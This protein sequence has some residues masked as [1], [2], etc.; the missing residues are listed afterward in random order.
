MCGLWCGF[1][2]L[3]ALLLWLDLGVLN[4]KAHVIRTREALRWT[5]FWVSVSLAFSVFV[6][7]LYQRNWFG[8]GLGPG[9]PGSGFR[10][11]QQYVTGYVVEASLSLDNVFVIALI[12]QYFRVPGEYQHRTLF[13]GIVGAMVFRGLMIGAGSA[14]VHRFEWTLQVFGVILLLTALRML[15]SDTD[16]VEPDKNPLVKL[17]RRFYPVTGSYEGQRFVTRLPDGRRAVT[18]L[19]L[20]LL[21]IES[22]DIL[23]AVDSIPAIFGITRDPFIVFSSNVFAILGLRSLYFALAGMMARFE[24]MKPSLVFVLLF[25]AVK[26]LLPEELTHKMPE[27]VPLLV[28]FGILSVG[29][30]ASVVSARRQARRVDDQPVLPGEESFDV[31]AGD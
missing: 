2:V 3:V 21:V 17:A 10:A 27:S 20:V 28:I 15:F 30:I 26:M 22:T 14:L 29:V 25:I 7:Y 16:S 9:E 8:I 5:A 18:P 12:F 19:M 11:W 31:E 1:V 13:W 24:Y 6:Y 4:R 23:F